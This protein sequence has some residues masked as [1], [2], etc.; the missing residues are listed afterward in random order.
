MI[1]SAV[2]GGALRGASKIPLVG[3]IEVL[4]SSDPEPADQKVSHKKIDVSHS[5]TLPLAT[6]MQTGHIRR[7]PEDIPAPVE[8]MNHISASVPSVE[9]TAAPLERQSFKDGS[10]ETTYGDLR[11]TGAGSNSTA[12]SLDSRHAWT[13]NNPQKPSPATGPQYTH[14]AVQSGSE[15]FARKIRDAVHKAKYYP[16][17]AK[18]RG[19]EGKTTVEFTINI[20]GN[21]ENIRVVK[22]SGSEILDSAAVETI[23]RAAPLPVAAGKVEV[24]II[25]MLKDRE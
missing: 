15:D 6:G 17:L 16:L 4:L 21:P 3:S 25:F 11:N 7:K 23:T 1:I 12:A 18:K 20:K 24:P 14:T 10:K 2:A 22:S 8:I 13:G 9:L 5:K 19:I